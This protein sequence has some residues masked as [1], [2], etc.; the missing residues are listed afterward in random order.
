MDMVELL[1]VGPEEVD[2]E[3]ALRVEGGEMAWMAPN[4][5]EGASTARVYCPGGVDGSGLSLL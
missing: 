2:E 3:E 5:V 4:S 1:S